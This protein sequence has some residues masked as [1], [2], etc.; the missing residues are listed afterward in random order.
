V[1]NGTL[2]AL[3]FLASYSGRANIADFSGLPEIGGSSCPWIETR[4]HKCCL[5]KELSRLS[6][7]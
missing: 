4:G 6:I 2:T 3:N 5:V 7:R 1:V